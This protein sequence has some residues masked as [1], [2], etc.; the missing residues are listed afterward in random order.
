MKNTVILNVELTA[1]QWKNKWEKE[2]EKNKTLK[3]TITFLETELNRWRG[4]EDSA[5]QK[6]VKRL[7]TVFTISV[8]MKQDKE[9][10]KLLYL[11]YQIM[12]IMTYKLKLERVRI[13]KKE[14]KNRKFNYYHQDTL[15]FLEINGVFS[16]KF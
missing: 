13:I 16:E 1:E 2:K 5:V 4:G 12:T 9:Y 14:M 6:H 8:K 11:Y 3:N 10:Q 15:W 7:H